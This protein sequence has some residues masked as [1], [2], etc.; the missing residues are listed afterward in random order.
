MLKSSLIIRYNNNITLK[1]RRFL[2]NSC[3]R[4]LFK[5]WVPELL[6]FRFHHIFYNNY[7]IMNTIIMI[8][9]L[10]YY[11][12]WASL[13]YLFSHNPSCPNVTPALMTLWGTL[14][15]LYVRDIFVRTVL[16]Y[17]F[18]IKNTG[19]RVWNTNLCETP[20]NNYCLTANHPRP[21]IP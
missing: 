8:I 14:G 13:Y 15:I 18:Y 7:L 2:M 12:L 16:R 5:G 6:F 17:V 1:Q 9:L 20:N 10:C 4:L 11:D 3:D 21:H 19:L